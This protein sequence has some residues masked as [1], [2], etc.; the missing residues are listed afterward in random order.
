LGAFFWL[1]GV[2]DADRLTPAFYQNLVVYLE[3]WCLSSIVILLSD[4]GSIKKQ[5]SAVTEV[6][7]TSIP[8]EFR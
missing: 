4:L 6:K 5:A 8:I 2:V 1:A 3:A 7:A